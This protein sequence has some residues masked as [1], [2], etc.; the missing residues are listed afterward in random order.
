MSDTAQQSED[1]DRA[2]CSYADKHMAISE[3][4]QSEQIRCN[5]GLKMHMTRPDRKDEQRFC[6][7]H[8]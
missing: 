6:L 1:H 8:Q 7:H 4:H 3:Y 2:E 5:H